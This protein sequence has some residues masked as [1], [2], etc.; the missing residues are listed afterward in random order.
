M[1]KQCTV[2]REETIAKGDAVCVMGFDPANNRPTVKKATRDNLATSN[3]VFGV[4]EDDAA[5]GSVGVLVAGEVA[6]NAITSLGAGKS[7][8]VAPDIHNAT[9]E[10]PYMCSTRG[11]TVRWATVLPTTGRRSRTP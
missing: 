10:N 4:A 8:L 5:G 9:A 2:P 6:E 3:T 7:N 1:S 11:P